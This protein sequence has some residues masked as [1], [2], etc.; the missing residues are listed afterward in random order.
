[1]WASDFERELSGA[2]N[3]LRCSVKVLNCARPRVRGE[4]SSVSLPRFVDRA[5]KGLQGRGRFG[6]DRLNNAQHFCD[7][8][9][10]IGHAVANEN[11]PCF[12]FAG[13]IIASGD[14]DRR[15]AQQAQGHQTNVGIFVN[16]RSPVDLHIDTHFEPRQCAGPRSVGA[17]DRPR[18]A[19]ASRA[20][21]D[22]SRETGELSSLT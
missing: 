2:V 3:S 1:M 12:G 14:V 15:F 7:R 21:A 10:E 22:S 5:L 16:Q 18:L 19:A 11:L 20:A 13:M 17:R 6:R 8:F 9:R 4:S